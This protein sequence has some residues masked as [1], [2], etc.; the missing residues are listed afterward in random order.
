MAISRADICSSA[1]SPDRYAPNS[2]RIWSLGRASP[3]RL[4]RIRSMAA[5]A[6]SA[7]LA[8]PGE[9]I[10]CAQVGNWQVGGGQVGGSEGGGQQVA[11]LGRAAVGVDEQSR[12]ACFQEQLAA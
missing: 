2:Q 8:I 3:S 1:T 6:R 5:Y 12:A 7:T 10:G 9:R 11:Q 4:A